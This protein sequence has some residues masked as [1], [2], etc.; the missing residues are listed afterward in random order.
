MII[1]AHLYILL[2]FTFFCHFAHSAANFCVFLRQISKLYWWRDT[3]RF[4]PIFQIWLIRMVVDYRGACSSEDR[5]HSLVDTSCCHCCRHH[6]ISNATPTYM[7]PTAHISL[8]AADSCSSYHS[9]PN[10]WTTLIQGPILRCS[11]SQKNSSSLLKMSRAWFFVFMLSSLTLDIFRMTVLG[12]LSSLLP[13][14]LIF[15][16]C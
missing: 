2:P 3:H 5:L 14:W 16:L 15:N 10:I 4:A 6:S 13:G 12:P 9:T 11:C 1:I 8:V 7:C